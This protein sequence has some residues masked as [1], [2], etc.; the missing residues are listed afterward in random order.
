MVKWTSNFKNPPFPL[1]EELKNFLY[2]ASEEKMSYFINLWLSEGIPQ[3]IKNKPE[4]YEFLR[5]NLSEHLNIHSKAITLIGSARFGYSLSP[6]K[7]Y[8]PFNSGESDLDIGIIDNTSFNIFTN[9][10]FQWKKDY[11]EKRLTPPKKSYEKYWEE[12][13]VREPKKINRGIFDLNRIPALK[14]YQNGQEFLNYLSAQC[15]QWNYRNPTVKVKRITVRFYKDWRS[16]VTQ[17]IINL[18]S[19]TK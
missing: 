12:N 18:Q 17:N 13:K 4:E 19:L 11:E 5:M 8:R 3:F 2:G 1:R 7:N 16:F 15:N 9:E 6:K 10:F 14:E